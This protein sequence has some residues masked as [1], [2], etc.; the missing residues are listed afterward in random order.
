[1]RLDLD[2]PLSLILSAQPPC[3]LPS[4]EPGSLQPQKAWPALVH[5]PH[6]VA[7]KSSVSLGEAPGTVLSSAG[8]FGT[9]FPA[10]SCRGHRKLYP[11]LLPR[12]VGVLGT[13]AQLVDSIWLGALQLGS[14]TS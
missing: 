14:T 7:V 1:M 13:Q 9:S 11:S 8:R 6:A 2:R 5:P 10:R 12:V 4:Q 3:A